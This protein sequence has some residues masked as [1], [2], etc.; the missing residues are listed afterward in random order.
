MQHVDLRLAPGTN[1]TRVWHWRTSPSAQSS[2]PSAAAAP[3]WDLEAE[4]IAKSIAPG[5]I[6][7]L[8]RKCAEA[9]QRAQALPEGCKK[10]IDAKVWDPEPKRAGVVGGILPYVRLGKCVVSLGVF[11]C[12]IGKQ[13]PNGTLLEDMRSP[14]RPVSSVPDLPESRLSQQPVP[15]AFRESEQP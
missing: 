9:E 13:S 10:R 14:D 6:K 12:S 4:T 3:D 1:R 15:R 8:Q 7:E 2:E 5:M 11:G